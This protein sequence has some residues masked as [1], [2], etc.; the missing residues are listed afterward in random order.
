MRNPTN[1]EM[2]L[3]MF[4]KAEPVVVCSDD[5]HLTINVPVGTLIV[6]V[7]YN[8]KTINKIYTEG[9]E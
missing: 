8:G 1:E 4:P 3:G 7:N 5:Y 9:A 2:S 6:T